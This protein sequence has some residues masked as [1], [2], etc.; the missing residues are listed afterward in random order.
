MAKKARKSSRKA[1]ARA[2]SPSDTQTHTS[3][4]DGQAS[5]GQTSKAML[6]SKFDPLVAKIIN[7]RARAHDETS[8]IGG[9]VTSAVENDNA[10]KKALG[11]AVQLKKM[12]SLKA[13]ELLFHFHAYVEYMGLQQPDMLADRNE[14]AGDE[15]EQPKD[16]LQPLQ[17]NGNGRERTPDSNAGIADDADLRGRAQRQPGASADSELSGSR[18]E[19]GSVVPLK[20]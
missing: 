11:W 4:A 16:A 10:H 3:S 1:R 17:A 18:S 5:A 12:G 14:D 8:A 6:K 19:M 7:A 15:D 20:H 9:W 2:P 13:N